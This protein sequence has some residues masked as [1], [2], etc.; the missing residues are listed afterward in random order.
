MMFSSG[1]MIGLILDLYHVLKKRFRLKGWVVSLLDLVYWFVSAGLVFS[2]LMWSNWGELRF[3]IFIA[4]LVG[5]YLY[6]RY[7]SEQITPVIDYIVQQVE[8][9]IRWIWTLLWIPISGIWAIIRWGIGILRLPI[10]WL[11][12]LVQKWKGYQRWKQWWS[13]NKKEG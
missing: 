12:G 1:L 2:L 3:S 5:V 6:F 7:C 11:K 8:R 4:I 13:K 10:D 9:L